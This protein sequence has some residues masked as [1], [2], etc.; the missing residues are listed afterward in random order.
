[1]PEL[2][3]TDLAASQR[4]WCDL[5]GFT[6]RYARPGEGFAYLALGSAHLMLDQAGLGRT[7]ITAPF[8]A[9]LGRGVNFQ[10]SVPSVD[11]LLARLAAA[12][13]PLFGEPEV[14]WYRT[15]TP[16]WTAAIQ[17]QQSLG[18]RPPQA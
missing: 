18:P 16:T 12:H 4:F 10:V 5:L 1:V 8:E 2:S 9:P 14:K 3:V 6:V 15:G 7:W 17:P 11:P 13:W